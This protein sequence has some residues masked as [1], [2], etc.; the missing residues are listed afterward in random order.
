MT[1][2]RWTRLGWLLLLLLVVSWPIRYVQQA[3]FGQVILFT[4]IFRIAL[5]F[6]IFACAAVTASRE[7]SRQQVQVIALGYGLVSLLTYSLMVVD[8]GAFYTGFAFNFFAVPAAAAL[9]MLFNARYFPQ[10]DDAGER[11]ITRTLLMIAAPIAAFGILQFVLNDPILHVGFK[12]VPRNEFGG[13]G[14]A[15][16][17]LTELVATH[18]IRANAIFGSALEFGHFGTLFAI[19]SFALMLK[20]RRRPQM[21]LS[22]ALLYLLFVC[23]VISTDTRNLLLYIASCFIG[24]WLIRGG[25]SVRALVMAALALVG[26]FYATIYALVAL[27]PG[28]FAGF[29]DSISLFQRARGVYVTVSQYI[30]NADSLA[31]VLFGYGYMQSVD[32]KFLPTTIFDNSELDVYL[33]AGVCGVVLYLTLLLALF[34]FAVRQWRLTGRVAWLA[35]ASLL[36]GTPLFSTLNIDLDQPFFVFVFALLAGG[37]ALPDLNPGNRGQANTVDSNMKFATG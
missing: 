19:L 24:F 36:F 25:M 15:A 5:F 28:F 2:R 7:S 21:A 13:A 32:F 18:H 23:A 4:G 26:L 33:Y 31:H 12:G 30:V 27:A 17:R 22:Y 1:Q 8:F 37:V 10:R 14:Q 16:I 29:L 34:I 6:A 20:Y 11:R 3:V 35:A 9:I